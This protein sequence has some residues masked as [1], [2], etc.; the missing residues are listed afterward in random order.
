MQGC[1]LFKE[2]LAIAILSDAITPVFQWNLID[3]SLCVPLKRLIFQSMM[4]AITSLLMG[5][6]MDNFVLL[7]M[8]GYYSVL[9]SYTGEYA[10]GFTDSN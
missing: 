1:T 8:A 2:F 5:S 4:L 7:C 9:R 3:L 10:D 6:W